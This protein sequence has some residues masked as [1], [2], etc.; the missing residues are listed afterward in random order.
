M[1]E[2]GLLR[3]YLLKLRQSKLQQAHAR[4]L[5]AD[6]TLLELKALAGEAELCDRIGKAVKELSADT[7]QF[8]KDYLS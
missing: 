2:L 8:I 6:A 1:G 5:S 7:A 3:E 4:A